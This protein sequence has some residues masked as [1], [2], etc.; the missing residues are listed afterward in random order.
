MV[1]RSSEQEIT[2]RCNYSSTGAIYRQVGINNDVTKDKVQY[3][4]HSVFIMREMFS[5]ERSVLA[6][7]SLFLV[8]Y[9]RLHI[10]EDSQCQ[11]NVATWRVRVTTVTI[12]TQQCILLCIVILH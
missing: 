5:Y 7:F 1:P 11:C 9:C 3:N 10:K 4:L 6:A 2:T 12:E 8:T